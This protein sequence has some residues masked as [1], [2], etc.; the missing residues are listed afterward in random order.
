[1]DII[2]YLSQCLNYSLIYYYKNILR[3]CLYLESGKNRQG[4][5]TEWLPDIKNTFRDTKGL[6]A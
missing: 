3:S 6:L 4:K 5:K 2:F 1:M